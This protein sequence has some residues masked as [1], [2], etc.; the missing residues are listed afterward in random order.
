MPRIPI[1]AST[2]TAPHEAYPDCGFAIA[3]VARATFLGGVG[4]DQFLLVARREFARAAAMSIAA[5]GKRATLSRIAAATG[6]SRKDLADVLAGNAGKKKRSARDAKLQPTFRIIGTWQSDPR[7]LKRDGSP[8]DLEFTGPEH[9]FERLV[10]ECA[11]DVAPTA[12]ARELTRMCAIKVTTTG[13]YKLLQPR[14]LDPKRRRRE[15]ERFGTQLANFS[16]ALGDLSNDDTA[17]KFADAKVVQLDRALVPLFFREYSERAAALLSS[18]DQWIAAHSSRGRTATE[19]EKVG[20]GAYLFM[21]NQ[22]LGSSTQSSPRKP[23]AADKV[24]IRTTPRRAKR[25]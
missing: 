18:L 10:R 25:A 17:P 23:L 22:T 19:Q 8:K 11:S 7:F 14:A 12:M 9:S 3:P 13:R 16:A 21:P 2:K 20:L 6:L 24:G 15:L 5:S 4:V 1:S